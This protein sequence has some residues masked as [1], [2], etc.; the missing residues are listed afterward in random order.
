MN[1]TLAT[2]MKLALTATVISALIFIVCYKMLE[3]ESDEY[4]TYIET[5]TNDALR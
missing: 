3:D 4:K 2:F 1:K 5:H